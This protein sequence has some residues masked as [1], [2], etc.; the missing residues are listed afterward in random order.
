MEI[1]SRFLAPP[2]KGRQG[3]N[4][5]DMF[6]WLIYRQLMGCSYRDLESMTGIDY[7]TFIKFRK[8]LLRKMWFPRVFKILTGEITM[9]LPS[10]FLLL[11]SSFVQSYSKRDEQGAEYSGFKHKVGFKLHQVIDFQTRLPLKQLCTGG[12]RSDIVLGRQLI[13]GSPKRWKVK[14]VAADKGYD[15]EDFVSQIRHRWK[16]AQVAIPLR[17][18]NQKAMGAKRRQ[19]PRDYSLKAAWRTLLPAFLNKRTEI[20]RYFSRKKRVFRLGEERTRGLKNFRANSYLT[21]L[22]EILEFLSKNSPLRVLFTK[23]YSCLGSR[24]L[25]KH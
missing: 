24:S 20:E 16:G 2:R 17:R 25:Q 3:Y 13:R 7:S 19:T 11:D 9:G 23:L 21:S 14:A 8:R 1:L 12:A 15:A 4:K 6:R 18:T 10:L 22:M 5:V